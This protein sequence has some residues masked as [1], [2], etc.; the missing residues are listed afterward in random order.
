MRVGTTELILIFA[1]ALVVFG[2]SKLPELG[3]MA[4]KAIG[5]FKH[6]VNSY[7]Q[8]WET[9]SPK[10]ASSSATE[11]I[12]SEVGTVQPTADKTC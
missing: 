11:A 10:K 4:G 12:E 7:D 5:S 1:V 3:R 6:Y 8:Q 9:E 2:P